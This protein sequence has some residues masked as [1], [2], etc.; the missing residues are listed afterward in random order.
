MTH[1]TTETRIAKVIE[2]LKAVDFVDPEIRM[3]R[4]EGA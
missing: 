4:V 3:M 1:T 2:A